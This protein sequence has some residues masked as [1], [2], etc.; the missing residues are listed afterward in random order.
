MKEGSLVLKKTIHTNEFYG[1]EDMIT[2]I[3]RV[4]IEQSSY[5]K[6]GFTQMT[7]CAISFYLKL[8]GTEISRTADQNDPFTCPCLPFVTCFREI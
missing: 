4:F 8:T 1:D 2:Q 5:I 7:N 3:K 6:L